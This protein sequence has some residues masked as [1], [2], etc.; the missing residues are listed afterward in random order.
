VGAQGLNCAT[1]YTFRAMS[2]QNGIYSAQA[3]PGIQSFVTLAGDA[4]SDSDL[5]CDAAD[6]CPLDDNP[7]QEDADGNGIGDACEAAMCFPIKAASQ[8]LAVI[9]L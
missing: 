4:D 3:A 1:S 7:G 8:K 6:N 5:I 2:V 9:C